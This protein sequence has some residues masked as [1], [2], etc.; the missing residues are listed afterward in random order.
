MSYVSSLFK[1]LT[2][3]TTGISLMS[4]VSSLFKSLTTFLGF[5]ETH[6]WTK[7]KIETH[8]VP[9]KLSCYVVQIWKHGLKNKLHVKIKLMLKQKHDTWTTY[10]S[11]Q[12][13]TYE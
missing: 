11:Q 8:H 1:S 2:T 6:R 9:L 10:A 12:T 7:K 13:N 5:I 4:Y 3:V